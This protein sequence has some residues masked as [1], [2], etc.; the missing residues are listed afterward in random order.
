MAGDAGTVVV[1]V[2]GDLSTLQGQLAATGAKGKGLS[3]TALGVAGIGAAAV[4]AGAGLI[5]LGGEFDQAY[6]TIRVGTGATG[7]ALDA[8]KD[9]FKAVAKTGPEGFDQVGTAVADLNTRLG[10]TGQPLQ[11][12]SRQILDLSRITDTDLNTNIEK[13]TRFLGD[14]GVA[15]EDFG[16]AI[17]AV[18]RAS[19]A[20]GPSV[21]EL[22]DLLVRYGAPLRQFGFGFEESAALLGKFQKEGVNTELVMGSLRIALGKFS[23]AGKDPVEGLIETTEAIKN[24]GSQADANA[25]AFETFGARAGADMAAAIREGRFD[26]EALFEQVKNG[27]ETI[28]TASEDT[29]SWQ[30]SLAELG[31]KAKVALEPAAVALF[32]DFGDIL[33]AAAPVIETVAT[34]VGLLAQVFTSLPGPVQA[35]ILGIGALLAVMAA[36]SLI[37]G[38]VG[39]AIG[40]VNTALT[41]LAANP[42]VL[43]IAAIVAAIAGLAY[44][45]YRNWDTIKEYLSATWEFI[46]NVA[47]TVWQAIQDAIA[48]VADWIINTVL[49]KWEQFT[50]WL[51]DVW[52]ALKFA[53]VTT[54][55]TIRDAIGGAAEWIAD[56]V[57]RYLINPVQWVIGLFTGLP[58]TARRT[59]DAVGDAISNAVDWLIRQFRRLRDS[60]LDALGP[61]GDI[62]EFGGGLIGG[63]IPGFDTGGVVP[64]PRGAP[65]LVMAHGGETILPT[66]KTGGMAA[67][68]GAG[69]GRPIVLN[70]NLHDATIRNEDD[71]TRLARSLSDETAAELRAAGVVVQDR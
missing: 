26:I 57:E 7:D 23:K 9:D 55:N 63:L 61:V 54:W 62:L 44:V 67:L 20:T 22:S 29:K 40:A 19:Q 31:N 5:S 4:A 43:I 59:W 3:K 46:K 58:A 6:D 30:E 52:N 64:G 16:D 15:S 66:H 24:A 32:E 39:A 71:I 17:D 45:I 51:G 35:I 38:P 53:A 11:D 37:G 68:Q 2:V 70:V 41:F 21:A 14:A 27:T 18:F 1:D 28:E 10:L 56:K 50:G 34:G 12:V 42:I 47:S 36:L 25:L 48:A 33:E 69:G 65:R 49:P 8:L 13:L 60:A